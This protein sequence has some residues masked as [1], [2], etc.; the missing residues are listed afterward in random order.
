MV[1]LHNHSNYSILQGTIPIEEL[2][3]SAKEDGAP[4]ISLTDTNGMY[5]SIK[6]AKK[7]KEQNLKAI[8]GVFI[9]DPNNKNHY[10]LFLAKNLEGYSTICK[11]TTSRK[12]KEDFSLVNI[13]DENLQNVIIIT[14]SLELLEKIYQKERL[15]KNLYVELIVTK[16]HKSKTRELYNFAKAK[17]LQ[18]V[19]SNPTYF[20]KPEDHLLQKVVTAIKKNTTLENLPEDEIIDEE[21]YFKQGDGL[22]KTWRNLPE[23]ILNAEKIANMCNV[24][25]EFGKNKFPLFDLPKG[26]IASSYLRKIC[27]KGLAERYKPI[28][29]HALARLAKE[30]DVIDELGFSHY[31][32]V[33]HDIVRE[34]KLRRMRTL[35]RGSAANSLVSYCLGFTEIDPIKHNLYFE[36]FLNRAR[37]SPPDVDLDFSW[38]ERD[39]IVKYVY[40]KYGYDKVAMISTTVTFRARSAFRETAKVFGVSE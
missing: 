9:D 30:L 21:Y 32:L 19:A 34:A 1:S 14:A 31:F 12:L 36:R 6:F 16:Q 20:L 38:R 11:I 25:L 26:E 27:T 3:A 5:G 23:A 13:F 17:G 33:V 35:G 2:I 37:T 22:E 29:E 4:C 15:R 40:D 8:L 10:A 39:E 18:V 7:A 24:D 28:T